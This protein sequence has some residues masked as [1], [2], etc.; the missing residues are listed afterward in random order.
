LPGEPRVEHRSRPP[1]HCRDR[2]GLAQQPLQ[3][4]DQCVGIAWR[5]GKSAAISGHQLS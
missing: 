4:I 5:D 3:S 2:F 1:A